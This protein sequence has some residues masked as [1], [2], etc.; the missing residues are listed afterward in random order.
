[1]VHGPRNAIRGLVG[2]LV[3]GASRRELGQSGTVG[4]VG[5]VLAVDGSDAV[6]DRFEQAAG[7]PVH[8][9]DI[10]DWCA[11]LNGMGGAQE[12]TAFRKQFQSA[13]DLAFDVL[14]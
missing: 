1:M 2:V 13:L 10:L 7:R 11:H 14:F 9:Q 12:Q 8:R 3:S 6:V 5:R 4:L